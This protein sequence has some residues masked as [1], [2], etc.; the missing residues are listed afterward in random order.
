MPSL[1]LDESPQPMP[2]QAIRRSLRFRTCLTALLLVLCATAKTHAFNGR[3]H[4][5]IAWMAF[6]Q[7]DDKTRAKIATILREHPAEAKWWRTARFNPRD[8]RLGLF[9]NASVFPDQ[10]RPDTEFSRYFRPRA[11]YINY[12]LV[13]ERNKPVRLEEP[14]PTDENVINTYAAHL[15]TLKEPKN[16]KAE[17]AVA[18]SWV[19]HQVADIHQP[20]HA[21]ARVCPATPNGDQ[22]GNLVEVPNN[23]GPDNLHAYW[24]GILGREENPPSLDRTARQLLRDYPR[25]R[26]SKE[27]EKTA[28]SDWVREGADACRDVVYANLAIDENRF[29]DLPLGYEAGA[30]KLAERKA[31]LAAYRLADVLKKIAAETP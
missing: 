6:E 16:T 26:F 29:R 15:K 5:L 9:L 2:L 24:D 28:I 20:L 31:A 10:A 12:R 19:I 18:L 1:P 13:Y 14:R 8:E 25:E 7:L 30:R 11:H 27:L 23:N 22:G 17:R 3:G 21:A 4:R